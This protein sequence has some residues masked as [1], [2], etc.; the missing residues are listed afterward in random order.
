MSDPYAQNIRIEAL[1][2]AVRVRISQGTE[3]DGHT[4]ER[5]RTYEAFLD[6]NPVTEIV[7]AIAASIRANCTLDWDII[8]QGSDATVYGVADWIENPPEWITTPWA[9]QVRASN[10]PA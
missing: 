3:P 7:K 1:D 6:G 5:A 8:Q 10:K 2:R 9:A 4:V